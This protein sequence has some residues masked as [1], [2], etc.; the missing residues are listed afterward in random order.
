MHDALL[1][2]RFEGIGNLLRE[3]HRLV[4][5]DPASAIRSASVSP[6]TN[7]I[8]SARTGGSDEPPIRNLRGRR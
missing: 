1:V 2:R 8:T 7:S 3:G 4:E 5:R 6:S